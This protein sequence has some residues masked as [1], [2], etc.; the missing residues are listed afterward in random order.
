MIPDVA[1]LPAGETFAMTRRFRASLQ[2]LWDLWTTKAGIESWW[3]PPGFAVTVQA[4]DLRPGGRLDY[5][6]TAVAP[7]MVAYMQANGMPVATPA[8]ITYAEVT[9]LKRLAY[10]HLVDFIPDREPYSTA[11]AVDFT[12]RGDTAEMHL[13][14]QRM[15]DAEWS[16]RQ[17][18][19]WEL[20]LGKLAAIL[21]L[22]G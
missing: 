4:I 6:M 1:T 10:E 15:H 7:E 16:E 20:E 12:A 22:A 13:T 8:Q 18:Q 19:G 2:D 9:P 5:T 17:R 11:L 3:G 21:P 14:F